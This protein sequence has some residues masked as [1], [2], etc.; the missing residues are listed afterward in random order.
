MVKFLHTESKRGHTLL[1]FVCGDRVTRTLQSALEV[2]AKLNVLLSS[3]P[4]QFASMVRLVI[5]AAVSVL[6]SVLPFLLD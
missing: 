3:P 1:Y 2:Q 4:D 5:L 6:K